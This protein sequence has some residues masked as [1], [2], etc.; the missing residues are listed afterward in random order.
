MNTLVPKLLLRNAI[1][2]EAALRRRSNSESLSTQ[3]HPPKQS[4]ADKC[5][6]K[7]EL[8]NEAAKTLKSE[9]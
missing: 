7:Q 8:G 4:F 9:I 1:V 3:E 2:P 5:V 6:P